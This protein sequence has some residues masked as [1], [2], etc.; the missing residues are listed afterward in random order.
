MIG[1]S[2]LA[3]TSMNQ[4]PMAACHIFGK[5]FQDRRK[6]FPFGIYSIPE[7]SMVGDNEEQLT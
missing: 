1:F 3:S 6:L 4:G 7:I 5:K 2:A